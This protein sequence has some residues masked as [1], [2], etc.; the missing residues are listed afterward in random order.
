MAAGVLVWILSSW[1]RPELPGDLLG[2]VACL[3]TMLV[4]TPLSRKIDPPR[5]LV[6]SDGEKVELSHRLG[7]IWK[8]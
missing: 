7:I 3:L 8:T 6:A 2:M 1:L 4:V 5:Q